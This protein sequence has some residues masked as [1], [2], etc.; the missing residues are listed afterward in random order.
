[1]NI[2][3]IL[4]II[5][6][7]LFLL[8]SIFKKY[9][10]IL[11]EKKNSPTFITN[12]KNAKKYEIITSTKIPEMSK[13]GYSISVWVWIDDINW[14]KKELKHILYRGIYNAP[15]NKCQPCLIFNEENDLS[16][17]FMASSQLL[18]I[19]IFNS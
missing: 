11:K 13:E 3:I 8:Y 10:K 9:K 16:I 15:K 1:M 5:V 12:T 14:K 7:I 17:Y 6:I 18:A 2:T 19:S 4:I